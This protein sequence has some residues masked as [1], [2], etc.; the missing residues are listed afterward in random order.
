MGGTCWVFHELEPH[1]H[2]VTNLGFLFCE[3][4]QSQREQ[5]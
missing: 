3:V 5:I 4:S 1:I 2:G